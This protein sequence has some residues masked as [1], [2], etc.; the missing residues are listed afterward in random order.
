MP[1]LAS[2][3]IHVL[4]MACLSAC[5]TCT[6]VKVKLANGLQ[7][8]FLTSNLNSHKY[9]VAC[10]GYMVESNP[11]NTKYGIMY[12]NACL[13]RKGLERSFPVLKNDTSYGVT[14]S[15]AYAHTM[16][17]QVNYNLKYI[18]NFGCTDGEGCERFWSYLNGFV[19][20]MRSMYCKNRLLAITD[21]VEH[22]TYQKMLELQKNVEEEWK[23]VK[24]LMA[25][26]LSEKY[27]KN[28]KDITK[29]ITQ[30]GSL[31]ISRKQKETRIYRGH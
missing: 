22:F 20:V 14:A 16:A 28:L 29:K 23:S 1:K 9:A 21:S 27:F 6:V 15:H 7:I 25:L 13:A 10:V 8:W 26:P 24:E 17:C 18:P 30:Q 11:E 31:L 3:R 5:T 12:E 4:D 19:S 2:S